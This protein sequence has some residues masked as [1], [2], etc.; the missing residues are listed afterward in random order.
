MHV[1]VAP[2]PTPTA[3]K[4]EKAVVGGGNEPG[5]EGRALAEHCGAGEVV[6]VDLGWVLWITT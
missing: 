3:G 1:D 2:T 5:S 6:E 4:E